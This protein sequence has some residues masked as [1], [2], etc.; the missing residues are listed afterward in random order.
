VR[1]C[2]CVCVCVRVCVCVCVCECTHTHTHTHKRA[3]AHTHTHIHTHTHTHTHARTHT[4]RHT[5]S[6]CEAVLNGV[7]PAAP[8]ELP[9][10]TITL[11]RCM[12]RAVLRL[13][14]QPLRTDARWRGGVAAP[15][16]P[17][18]ACALHRLLTPVGRA[19]L[20]GT[21]SCAMVPPRVP[22]RGAVGRSW[23]CR[24]IIS[25]SVLLHRLPRA[26]LRFAA[27]GFR[28]TRRSALCAAPCGIAFTVAARTLT[29]GTTCGQ[30]PAA[31]HTS[32]ADGCR[33]H[34]RRLRSATE[35]VRVR[36]CMRSCA[37]VQAH[38]PDAA[39]G[40]GALV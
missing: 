24:V 14:R 18:Q 1:A 21:D 22:A 17:Q 6:S 3:R 12:H 23:C 7:P 30:K 33:V 8:S 19:T 16:T 13:R 35:R 20:A 2:V 15:K 34:G 5:H 39:R 10:A 31:A 25:R 27:I 26:A 36:V 11:A 29:V 37:R 28:R 38:G 4:H 32:A 9:P 40:G